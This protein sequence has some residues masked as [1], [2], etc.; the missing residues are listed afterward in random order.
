VHHLLGDRGQ[1]AEDWKQLMTM[2]IDASCPKCRRRFG[3]AGTMAT[4]PACPGCGYR[5]PQSE[6]DANAAEMDAFRELLK[7]RPQ[8]GTGETLRQQR[9]AA[10]L[11]LRQAA[12]QLELSPSTLSAL[13]QG[14]TQLSAEVALAMIEV[15]GLEVKP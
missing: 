4:M 10:G 14:Q 3:W 6:L 5:P 11:T 8:D 9:L 1:E 13:E 2:M 15:Y 12:K 7:T